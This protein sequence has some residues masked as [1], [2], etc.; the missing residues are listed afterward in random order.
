MLLIYGKV[1]SIFEKQNKSNS[2]CLG[3]ESPSTLEQTDM[4]PLSFVIYDPK[5]TLAS[6]TSQLQRSE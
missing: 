3:E 6:A 4:L 1:K 5:W 2:V